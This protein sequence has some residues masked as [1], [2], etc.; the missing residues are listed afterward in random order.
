VYEAHA[1]LRELAADLLEAWERFE[2]TPCEI[3]DAG[4]P[5]VV[6]GQVHVRGRGSGLELDYRVGGA[7]WVERGLIV[8]QRDFADWDEALRAAGIPTAANETR[9]KTA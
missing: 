8:R 3:V 6:L 5:V 1:G 2:V 4:N 7:Y 9:A